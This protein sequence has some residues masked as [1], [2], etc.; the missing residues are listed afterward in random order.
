MRPNLWKHLGV[1]H[2]SHSNEEHGTIL[3]LLLRTAIEI[4]LRLL[5]GEIEEVEWV[6]SGSNCEIYSSVVVYRVVEQ[7]LIEP[8]PITELID[9]TLSY[10]LHS[11]YFLYSDCP[12][13][14]SI[15]IS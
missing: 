8:C 7:R 13:Y 14:T 5:R 3:S 2:I 6:R 4:T 9:Y 1:E 15:Y 11:H 12:V 10:V